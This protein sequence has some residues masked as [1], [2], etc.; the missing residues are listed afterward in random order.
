MAMTPVQLVLA[1]ALDEAPTGRPGDKLTALERY[2]IELVAGRA[3]V[4]HVVNV[5]VAIASRA[6][7]MRSVPSVDTRHVKEAMRRIAECRR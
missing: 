6:S 1:V 7:A 2:A 5:A 4:D 3:A